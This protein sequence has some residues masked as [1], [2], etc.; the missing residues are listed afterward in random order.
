[1]LGTAIAAADGAWSF[2]LTPGTPTNILSTL[3][4]TATDLAG[5]VSPGRAIGLIVGTAAA[6]TLSASGAFA[7]IPNLILGLGGADVLNGGSGNDTLDG[8]TGADTMSGGAG[9]DTYVVDNVGDVVNEAVGGGTD[10]VLTNL[11]NYSLTANVENLT[12]TGAVS[13]SGTGNSLANVITGGTGNDT[14]TDG[15]NV[16]GVDTL[17]GG[18]GNDIYNVANVG[19][20]IIEGVGA[21]IDT[22]RTSLGSYTLDANVENLTY[23]GAGDFVG[24]GNAL[25]NVINGGAGAD[26]LDGGLN[27]AGVDTLVGGAGNDTYIVRN[28]GD[29]VTEALNGGTDTVLTALA[30]LTLAANVENLAYTGA[31]NFAGTGNSLANVINGGAGADTLDGGVGAD[32]LIG[33]AG[34]DIYVVDNAGDAVV[35]AAGGS[36]DTVR[37][38]LATYALG[39]NVENLTSTGA[40]AFRG[41]GNNLANTITGGAGADTL[42][43]GIN[44]VG[45]DT[46]IGGAGN[47][48]YNVSNVGDVIVEAAGGGTDTVRTVLGTYTLDANVENL[49]YTGAGTFTGTGNALANTIIGGAGADILD[50]GSNAAGADTLVGG[51]GNDTYFVRNAADVVTETA[52]GGTDTVFAAINTYTIGANVENLTFIGAGAFTGTGNTSANVI[53]GGAGADTLNGGAGSDTLIGGAGADGLT[54]GAGPDTFVLAKG[55]DNGDLITD[56][57][58]AGANAD[59]LTLTGY[60]AGATLVKTVTGTAATP[61][62]YAVQVGGVSQDTFQLTGNITLAAANFKFV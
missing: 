36:T 35:E 28:V 3:T 11:A 48:T 17:I 57:T 8:G 6:N 61:T 46:L 41:F 38:S 58:V 54:G 45:V 12:Y 52:G 62:S 20:V 49:T 31:G 2:T 51:A 18:A 26:T 27:L 10:L 44:A 7:A 4:A 1:L 32:T 23:T 34:D 60:A 25:A 50:G 13:F 43:D 59:L 47:D 24:T 42:T 29:V 15:A 5:N 9:D 22:V 16:A 33:G 56:F 30:S 55:D 37:T 14:L 39:A 21:G 19:D 40:G 53:T